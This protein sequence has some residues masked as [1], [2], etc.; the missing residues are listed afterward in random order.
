MSGIGPID[1]KPIQP[2]TTSE[3]GG[4][5]KADPVRQPFR[6]GPGDVEQLREHVRTNFDALQTRIR[7]GLTQGLTKPQILADL[8]GH[9]LANA[10]G[11]KVV[12]G[13]MVAAVTQAVQSNPKLTQVFDELFR[14]ATA[15]RPPR[16]RG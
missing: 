9:E 11:P 12:S 5:K 4:E 7:A 15:E 14:K 6:V 3:V 1:R 8:A 10:F 16:P 2:P 13:N